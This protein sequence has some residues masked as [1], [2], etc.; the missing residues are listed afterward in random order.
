M[1]HISQ[2]EWEQIL[3]ENPTNYDL[4]YIIEYTDKKDEA[5][6]ILASRQKERM[7]DIIRER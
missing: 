7:I 1:K 3:T 2:K 6:K 4:R 5:E